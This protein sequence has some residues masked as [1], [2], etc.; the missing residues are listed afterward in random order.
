MQSLPVKFKLGVA[1][2]DPRGHA[3]KNLKPEP[4]PSSD[5]HQTLTTFSLPGHEFVARSAASAPMPQ[6]SAAASEARPESVDAQVGGD[7]F[8]DI[9]PGTKAESSFE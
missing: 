9:N 4:V 8:D 6:T 5:D 7:L 3:G 1:V 2:C